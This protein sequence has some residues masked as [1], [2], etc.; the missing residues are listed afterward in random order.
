M[1][2]K[3]PD[4]RSGEFLENVAHGSIVLASYDNYSGLEF[5]KFIF[6]FAK[7]LQSD[8]NSF[9]LKLDA[10]DPNFSH[11][12]NCIKVPFIPAAG[13]DSVLSHHFQQIPGV[14]SG[15]FDQVVNNAKH[16]GNFSSIFYYTLRNIVDKCT[17]C[18]DRI[19]A[20]EEFTNFSMELLCPECQSNLSLIHIL[21]CLNYWQQ[22]F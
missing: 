17:V 3:I 13:D 7:H 11:L 21:H 15:I 8:W 20:I 9:D 2:G 6:N 5:G 4:P 1:H 12:W 18:K 10:D 16:D 22:S 19:Q 14:F